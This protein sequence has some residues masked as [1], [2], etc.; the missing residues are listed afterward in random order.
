[1]AAARAC[2]AAADLPPAGPNVADQRWYPSDVRV[3][4]QGDVQ[5]PAGLANAAFEDCGDAQLPAGVALHLEGRS[6]RYHVQSGC[7][8]QSV[9]IS[10]V[11]LAANTR[12][13]SA[14]SGRESRT[15]RERIAALAIRACHH[16]PAPD[17]EHRANQAR[18]SPHP[19]ARSC[20]AGRS[21]TVSGF[22]EDRAQVMPA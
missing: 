17:Q 11:K 16:A 18:G 3:Q 1:M 4:L 12:C 9:D 2:W 20:A 8:T 22:T 10:P 7:L 15:T 14:E 6:P 13:L 5:A 19:Q 21:R